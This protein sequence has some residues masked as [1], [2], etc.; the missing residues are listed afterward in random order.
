MKRILAAVAASFVALGL[1]MNGAAVASADT[2]NWDGVAQ[3][4]SGGNWQINTGN[5][6]YGG[7]QFAQS[8][9]E[10]YGGGSYAPRADLASK[11][12]QIAVAEKVLVGQGV[13]A[14]P[15]CGAYLTGGSSTPAPVVVDE[16]AETFG[17]APPAPPADCDDVAVFGLGGHGDP[18][19]QIYGG[20][21]RRVHYPA[22]ISPLKPGGAYDNAV[23]EGR[24]NMV[25]EVDSYAQ[26]CEGPIVVKGYSE[27]ARAAG[28][29]LEVLDDGPYAD[30]IEGHLYSDPKHP[31]GIED[32]L[33]GL[34][35]WGVS[36]TGP[37]EGFNV[38]VVSECNPAD[39]ICNLPFPQ[40]LNASLANVIGYLSG[41][42]NYNVNN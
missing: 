3:C 11:D 22:V 8:T 30:R 19:A 12:A 1:T 9:W 4:E 37:R 7:L 27:G 34:S 36:M 16:P 38:P 32:A 2:H 25:H 6:Y 24:D 26:R 23:R 42:H 15:V 39:G 13:G 20:D 18:A 5:G 33:Q 14:W 28:D 10:G 35:V 40:N 29:A 17:Y 31:G 41:A 21:V